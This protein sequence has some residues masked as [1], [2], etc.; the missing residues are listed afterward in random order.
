MNLNKIFLIALF[1]FSSSFAVTKTKVLVA[2]VTT[3]ADEPHLVES[4]I[5]GYESDGGRW[6]GDIRIDTAIS[7]EELYKVVMPYCYK[8]GFDLVLRNTGPGNY[9]HIEL[10]S[11]YNHGIQ[12]VSGTGSN[13]FQKF[14]GASHPLPQYILCGAGNTVNLTGYH[15]EF[16]DIHPFS[17]YPITNLKQLSGDTLI[18]STDI[19]NNGG[20]VISPGFAV[21]LS[22]VTGYSNNPN[23]LKLVSAFVEDNTYSKFKIIHNT[24]SGNFKK[25]GIAEMYYQSYSHAYIA[26]KLAFIKDSLNCTWW[27]ARYRMRMTSGNNGTFDKYDGYGKPNVAAALA[28]S[29]VIME[30]PFNALGTMGDV[31]EVKKSG[32]RISIKFGNVVNALK[33][34][35]YDNDRLIGTVPVGAG[36][37]TINFTE[38]NLPETNSSRPHRFWY[39]G[40]RGDKV[41]AGSRII[42]VE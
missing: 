22:G 14:G 20:F 36:F 26:G 8:N 3:V 13:V 7:G 19:K 9:A 25:G 27:E 37:S 38:F 41:S 24:V 11:F 10:D 17:H 12:I 33:Y 35:F 1:F 34:N 21:N 2:L 39:E 18:V 32:N 16:F 31:F 42:A 29:G 40:I 30:D 23:G 4:F 28:Y 6:A 15:C 5:A